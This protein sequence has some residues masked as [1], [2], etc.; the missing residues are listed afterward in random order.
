MSM[1]RERDGPGFDGYCQPLARM[2]QQETEPGVEYALKAG[3]VPF[4]EGT[5][6]AS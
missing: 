1:G 2:E 6:P 4:E 3:R 5:P